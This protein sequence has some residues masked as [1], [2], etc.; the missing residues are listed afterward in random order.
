M[1]DERMDGQIADMTDLTQRLGVTAVTDLAGISSRQM[2]NVVQQPSTEPYWKLRHSG[3]CQDIYF[4]STLDKLSAL[5]DTMQAVADSSGHPQDRMGIYLQPVVQG[6]NCHCEFNLFYDPQ[7]RQQ[8]QQTRNLTRTAVDHLASRGA[9]FSRPFGENARRLLNRD[10][11]TTAVLKK[12]KTI[13]DPNN[14]M[15]P[16]KLC[17]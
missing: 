8:V 12:V 3:G 4:L 2:L 15:N 5:T 6:V 14:I 1:P 17:F 9:F 10:A 11:E 7:N 13:F 16:G